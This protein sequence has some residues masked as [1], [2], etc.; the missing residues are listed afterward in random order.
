MQEL[1]NDASKTLPMAPLVRVLRCAARRRERTLTG[2]EEVL[3]FCEVP[4]GRFSGFSTLKQRYLV[5]LGTIHYAV[6][7]GPS[8]DLFRSMIS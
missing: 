7:N 4:S 8:N 6:G 3:G 5:D 1:T 2:A